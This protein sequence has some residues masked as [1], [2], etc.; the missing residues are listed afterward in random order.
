[1]IRT[2][3]HYILLSLPLLWV[4]NLYLSFLGHGLMVDG[5]FYDTSPHP[6]D[7]PSQGIF[8][9]TVYLYMVFLGTPIMYFSGLLLSWRKSY[10]KWLWVYLLVGL[11]GIALL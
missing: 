2:I 4:L 5:L 9:D 1:M 8:P 10:Y 6:E 3:V 7:L 11:G